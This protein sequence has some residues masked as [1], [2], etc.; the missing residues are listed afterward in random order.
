MRNGLKHFFN[1]NNKYK[2]LAIAVEHKYCNELLIKNGYIPV[3]N[4][5]NKNAPWEKY[6]LLNCVNHKHIL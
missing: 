2:I 4:Q 6:Y 3:K 1:N 5:Y